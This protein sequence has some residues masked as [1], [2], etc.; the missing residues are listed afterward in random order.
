MARKAIVDADD[1]TAIADSIR[2]KLGTTDAIFVKD[3][4]FNID[5]ITGGGDGM[6]LARSILNKTVTEYID[7]EIT[8]LWPWALA[9]C[10]ELARLELPN[11]TSIQEYGLYGCAGLTSFVAP[12]L[13]SIS[14]FGFHTC[15]SLETINLPVLDR[16]R[17][18]AFGA[19]LGLKKIDLDS[20]TFIENHAMEECQSLVA[21]ILRST[22]VCEL[23]NVNAFNRC[24]H[25]TGQVNSQTNPDGLKDGYFYVPR[26]LVEQYKVAANWS[27]L[28]D[29][30]RA[31]EDFPDICGG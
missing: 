18:Y 27:E 15:M 10:T 5:Q 23:Q 20:A 2:G 1:L 31:I 16:L 11:I 19:C 22:V 3:M 30:F 8:E 28:A 21:V 6:A 29:R 25:F 13:E 14:T 7:P 24:F 17:E 12:K 4:S 9:G 26:D